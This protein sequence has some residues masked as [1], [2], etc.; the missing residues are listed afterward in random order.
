MASGS[1]DIK[2]FNRIELIQKSDWCKVTSPNFPFNDYEFLH[3]L[4]ASG[5]A[6]EDTGWS[7]HYLTAWNGRDLVGATI[8]YKKRHSYGEYIFDW[9]W[10][11]AYQRHGV[12]YYPKLTSAIP[13]TPATGPKL[14]FSSDADKDDVARRLLTQAKTLAAEMKLSSL[15]YLFLEPSEL[16]YFEKEGFLI[17]H[18]FQYHWKNHSY[19]S[20]DDFLE[21][22]KPRKRK[23]ILREREQLKAENI[24]IRWLTRNELNSGHAKLFHQFYLA[25]IEKMGAIAYLNPDFFERIFASMAGEVFL[26]IAEKNE[27]PVAGALFYQKGDALFGRYWGALSEVRNLHFEV[28]YYQPIEWAI[29]NGIKLFE[30]GAQGEHKIARGFLPV[31]TYSAHWISHPAFREAISDFIVQE[32]KA[33]GE[34]MADFPVHSPYRSS[35]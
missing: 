3:A 1:G 20:F 18:S 31:V 7:P 30:A 32:K 34:L 26:V 23:Q 35:Q 25:T 19:A 4:E 17:R 28:C 13:F 12:Q 16:P 8:L 27:V 6:A 9:A 11:E 2:C 24:T 33:I 22:L 15:H 14:L 10:A 5:A 29:K 21:T